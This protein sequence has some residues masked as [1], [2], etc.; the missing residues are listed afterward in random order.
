MLILAICALFAFS[1]RNELDKIP[2]N[3]Q[4]GIVPKSIKQ[5]VDVF[6]LKY[7][8]VKECNYDGQ[9]FKFSI[10]NIVD[11]LMSCSDTGYVLESWTTRIHA[12]LSIKFDGKYE[13]LKVSSPS[14]IADFYRTFDFDTSA[15]RNLLEE[16]QVVQIEQNNWYF[17]SNFGLRFDT[18]TLINNTSYSIFI[19]QAYPLPSQKTEKI[20]MNMYKL[21]FIITNQKT[22]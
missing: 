17:K 7:G 16:W 14:C 15:V 12:Y 5:V 4:D 22:E 3:H 10:I 18:G 1:C 9:A 20:D 6:E 13:V 19:A 11:S 8:D 21:I 2:D